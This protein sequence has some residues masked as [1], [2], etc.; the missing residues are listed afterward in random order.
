MTAD[1]IEINKDQMQLQAHRILLME[2][3]VNKNESAV[4]T[5][6]NDTSLEIKMKQNDNCSLEE[7]ELTA[8]TPN[9]E[10]TEQNEDCPTTETKL[11]EE[12]S[13]M[14]TKDIKKSPASEQANKRNTK[15]SC[16]SKAKKTAKKRRNSIKKSSGITG[17]FTRL[18][19]S[20]G[21][22]KSQGNFVEF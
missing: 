13:L 18:V 20:H 12:S 14:K 17:I 10:S 1:P 2:T 4:E 5:Q 8:N 3:K 15:K 9:N 19:G 6:P 16:H 22:K 21:H 7:T 11:E